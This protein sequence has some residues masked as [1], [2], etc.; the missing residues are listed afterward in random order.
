MPQ[1]LINLGDV[2]LNRALPFVLILLGG[3]IVIKIVMMIVRRGMKKLNS[4]KTAYHLV[5]SVV[6]TVLLLALGLIAFSSLGIDMTGVIA[7]TSVFTLALS[8]SVQNS[9]T[10][11]I[12]GFTLLYTKPFKSG[13]YVE[14]A[15]QSGTVDTIGMAYTRLVTPDNKLIFIPN[16]AVVS[17]EITNYTV[18]GKRRLDIA[19]TASYD[20]PTDQVLAALRTAADV[21]GVLEEPAPFIAMTGYG[22]HGIN[23][24]IRIWATNENF[25]TV[26][27]AIMPRIRE[28]F[29]SH[30]VSMTY[31]HLNV[32]LEK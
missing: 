23:Y 20:D 8:L 10:N 26:N 2:A 32:H 15:G 21:P 29:E 31:P 24:V 9:L 1:W 12:G 27:N 17:A 18:L 19:I 11:L 5:T 14:I 7:L 3:M 16:N 28:Q 6:R 25:W 13:D 22:D 4:E 30:G